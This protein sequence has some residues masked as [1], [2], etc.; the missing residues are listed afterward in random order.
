MKGLYPTTV[1]T[2]TDVIINGN[3]EKY[4]GKV[5]TLGLVNGEDPTANYVQL[6][7]EST[8][9]SDTFT[10]DDYKALV[11][12]MFEGTITVSSDISAMPAVTNINLSEQGQIVG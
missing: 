7:M 10:K 3:W 12:G 5:A 9:W 6:P 1:D 4:A 8:Q 2:L 11:K